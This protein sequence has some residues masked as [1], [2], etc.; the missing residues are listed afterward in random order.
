[1]QIAIVE[2]AKLQIAFSLLQRLPILKF[3]GKGSAVFSN[4]GMVFALKNTKRIL[5]SIN[6]KL[7]VKNSRIRIGGRI[8]ESKIKG[9]EPKTKNLGYTQLFLHDSGRYPII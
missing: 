8:L 7:M 9:I 1:M 5:G 2:I 4:C 6:N 3:P